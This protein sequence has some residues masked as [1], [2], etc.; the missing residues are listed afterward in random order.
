[1]RI[2]ILIIIHY[3]GKNTK[4]DTHTYARATAAAVAASP[5]K[6]A[7]WRG[8]L[9]PSINALLASRSIHSVIIAFE[10]YV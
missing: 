3:T 4:I 2:I 9:F 6:I 7:N 8:Y 1:M 5:V 10:P